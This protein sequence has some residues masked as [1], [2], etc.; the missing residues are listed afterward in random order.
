[1]P[2]FA[3]A[4]TGAGGGSRPTSSQIQD[5]EKGETHHN[6]VA[7]AMS[8]AQHANTIQHQQS[9]SEA[10]SRV[11]STTSRTSRWAAA[12][13]NATTPPTTTAAIAKTTSTLTTTGASEPSKVGDT[14]VK[15]EKVERDADS[16]GL[17][18]RTELI[19]K[20][21]EHIIIVKDIRPPTQANKWPRV[22]T[23]GS[24]PET[25]DESSEQEEVR[26]LL[27]QGIQQAGQDATRKPSMAAVH[28]K[29]INNADYQQIIASLTDM[30][31]DLKLE[32]QK[33]NM[34]VSK[35]D[36]TITQLVSTLSAVNA[37]RDIDNDLVVDSSGSITA[38]PLDSKETTTNI[39]S[40]ISGTKSDG[41]AR[42]EATSKAVRERDKERADKS[43]HRVVNR[44][45]PLVPSRT[46]VS[47]SNT[48][49]SPKSPSAIAPSSTTT[50]TVS[51]TTMPVTSTSAFQ[52]QEH[53]ATLTKQQSDTDEVRAMLESEIAEQDVDMTDD[54]QDETSKL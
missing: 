37:Q 32:I 31:V 22:T 3:A 46:N 47:G 6:H 19:C 38:Q 25:I 20:K 21:S 16:S 35:I 26:A 12:L 54:D 1:M 43:G 23:G 30:R 11:S 45:A 36:E 51:S 10:D 8:K 27:E 29:A 14:G 41:L 52:K 4:S 18:R 13:S 50:T 7:E 28:P 2:S 40:V 53:D 5:V 24:R 17:G 9:V 39:K 44:A 42:K 15:E 33:L 49:T 48:T 34:K